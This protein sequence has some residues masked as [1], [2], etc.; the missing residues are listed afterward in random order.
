L[1]GLGD[2]LEGFKNSMVLV[3]ICGFKPPELIGCMNNEAAEF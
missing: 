1:I 3:R 2:Q